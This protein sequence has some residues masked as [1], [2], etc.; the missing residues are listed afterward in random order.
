MEYIIGLI[1]F[2]YLIKKIGSKSSSKKSRNYY[3]QKTSREITNEWASECHKLDD[4]EFWDNLNKA[5]E[6]PSS[7]SSDI[8]MHGYQAKFLLTRNEW[9]EHKKLREY[10]EQKS[11]IVCPKVRLLDIIEPVKGE[12]Y[13]TRF[14]KIQAK[15][16]DFVITD[17]RMHIKA[18]LEL[19]DASH[20][21]PERQE[22]DNFVD[23][24]LSN[25]GY[26][27]IRTHSITE[28]T[29]KDL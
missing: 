1:F 19:D 4:D 28:D 26:K 17:Q 6:L 10:A 18:I 11:L 29:L 2:L 9:H 8:D 22:R 16:V 5:T 7:T 13:M 15:H 27:V 23:G 3:N 20:N 14:H 21:S 25:V 24:I 12:G